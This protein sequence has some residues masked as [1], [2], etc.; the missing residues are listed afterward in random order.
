[1]VH[2]SIAAASGLLA[3]LTVRRIMLYRSA[4]NRLLQ[5][6]HI[7]SSLLTA[8]A[9]ATVYYTGDWN[10]HVLLYSAAGMAFLA[11][12]AFPDGSGSTIRRLQR[13]IEVIASATL[14]TLLVVQDKVI[15]PAWALYV[16]VGAGLMVSMVWTIRKRSDK[17][18]RGK[19]ARR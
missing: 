11:T 18:E 3:L 13:Q 10:N 6:A 16:S 1:M 8:A 4:D 5:A 14:G 7:F 19:H 2:T 15:I 9:G 12:F 17:P